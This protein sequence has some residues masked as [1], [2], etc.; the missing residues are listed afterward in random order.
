[1]TASRNLELIGISCCSA[2]SWCCARDQNSFAANADRSPRGGVRW[3]VSAA[4]QKT[5][6]DMEGWLAVVRAMSASVL[7]LACSLMAHSHH[8]ID[9][10]GMTRN[11]PDAARP[12]RRSAGSSD[13][14]IVP[15]LRRPCHLV[16]RGFDC[17]GIRQARAATPAASRHAANDSARKRRCVRA[18]VRWRQTL[19]VL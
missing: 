14:P 13:G 2:V 11:P 19:K 6:A 9:A 16:E 5:G 3:A 12:G 1:M 8:R 18:V 15:P 17:A 4:L 10:D 7:P